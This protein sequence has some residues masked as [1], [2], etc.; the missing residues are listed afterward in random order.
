MAKRSIKI[1]FRVNMR[2]ADII[3]KTFDEVRKICKDPYVSSARINR[4]VWIAISSD[5]KLR[6]HIMGVV[7]EHLKNDTSV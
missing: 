3:S 7:C 4:A 2:M 6:K 5:E 1:E